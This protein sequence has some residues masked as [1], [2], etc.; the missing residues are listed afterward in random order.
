MAVGGYFD[1][2]RLTFLGWLRGVK[3]HEFLDVKS[4]GSLQEHKLPVQRDIYHADRTAATKITKKGTVEPKT[5][6]TTRRPP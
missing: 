2:E 4:E 1:E 6:Y 3:L 5:I